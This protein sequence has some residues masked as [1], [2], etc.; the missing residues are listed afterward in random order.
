MTLLARSKTDSLRILTCERTRTIQEV[1][2]SEVVHDMQALKATT[3]NGFFFL[4]FLVVFLLV[5]EVLEDI[6][7]MRE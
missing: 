3:C 6:T 1:T 2:N 7:V 5:F 4:I